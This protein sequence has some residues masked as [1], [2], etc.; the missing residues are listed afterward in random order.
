M[1]KEDLGLQLAWDQ[2][3]HW[4][5]KT[6]NGVKIGKISAIEASRARFFFFF[7][8]ADFSPLPHNEEL[9]PRLVYSQTE[10]TMNT[11]IFLECYCVARKK[12]QSGVR[13]LNGKQERSRVPIF[14][15][16]GHNTI[17][18]PEIFQVFTIFPVSL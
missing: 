5:K 14:A 6:K 9:G 1:G 15:V 11:E 3:L 18:I 2:A 8:K 12:K 4:G 7:A 17:N 16:I 13:K 10:K